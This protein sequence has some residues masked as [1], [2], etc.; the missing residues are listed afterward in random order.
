MRVARAAWVRTVQFR[1]RAVMIFSSFCFSHYFF[2]FVS[3]STIPRPGKARSVGA[4][5]QGEKA[6]S[7]HFMFSLLIALNAIQHGSACM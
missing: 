6:F 1:F 2:G 4:G 7:W 5:R 3:R